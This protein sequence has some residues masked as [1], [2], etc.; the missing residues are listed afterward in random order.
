MTSIED[1]IRDGIITSISNKQMYR[2]VFIGMNFYVYRFVPEGGSYRG[3]SYPEAGYV[4][5][6][7]DIFEFSDERPP[8]FVLQ[9]RKES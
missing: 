5:A 1:K 6:W 8:S 7:S 9:R 4:L 2:T 3:Q